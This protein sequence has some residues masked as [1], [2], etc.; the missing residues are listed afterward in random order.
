MPLDTDLIRKWAKL[1]SVKKALEFKLAQ[2]NNQMTDIEGPILENM[3]STEISSI[4]M[5]GKTV[6][7]HTS[8]FA[9]VSSRAEAKDAIK[10]AG[11]DNLVSENY[12]ANSLSAL[13][14]E[15]R[16]EGKELPKAFAGV[17]KIGERNG[18]RSRKA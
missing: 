1:D 15:F 6:Y 7:V 8:Y 4:K 16:N 5:D 9:E 12:N 13:V 14:R 11:F 18:L 10:A 3:A 17:I 2:I